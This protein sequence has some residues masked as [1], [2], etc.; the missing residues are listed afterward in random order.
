MWK[1]YEI[2]SKV[3]GCFFLYLSLS[4]TVSLSLILSLSL[5]LIMQ[6]LPV[7]GF[8][9]SIFKILFKDVRNNNNKINEEEEE[10]KWVFVLS[11]NILAPY[12][13]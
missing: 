10:D 6:S 12:L 1:F 9:L 7:I 4:S 11:A 8:F 5:S 13:S 3:V 2:I